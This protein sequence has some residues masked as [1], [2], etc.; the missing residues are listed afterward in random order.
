MSHAPI[1]Q[2]GGASELQNTWGTPFDL[3][4]IQ[5]GTVTHMCGASF[6]GTSHT[7]TVHIPQLKGRAPPR[8]SQIF[9]TP[10]KHT[11]AWYDRP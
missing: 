5:H 6:Q 3:D 10:I 8:R 2:G 1:S 4:Q 11:S 7:L 9:G